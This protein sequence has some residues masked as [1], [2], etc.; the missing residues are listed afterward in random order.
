V[1]VAQLADDRSG[2]AA[3]RT[4]AGG[5]VVFERSDGTVIRVGSARWLTGLGITLPGALPATSDTRVFVVCDASAI[6]AIDLCDP[7]RPGADRLV[8]QLCADGVDVAV[9]SGDADAPVQRVANALGIRAH[10]ECSPEE[11]VALIGEARARGA[12]VAFAGDGINDSTA[13]A[14]ADIGIAV[15]GATDAAR[16]AASVTL[17]DGDVTCVPALFSLCARTRRIIRQNLLFAVAYNVLAIP[18]ALAGIVH[19]AIA[20]LAMAGSSI[21]VLANGWRAAQPPGAS[22]ATAPR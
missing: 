9:L 5:G 2:R 17:E 20:A 12:V 18:A 14:A 11:K 16:A 13:L 19:P 4:V 10:A 8:Q 1:P 21:T 7:V 22:R 15:G 6:G 3:R